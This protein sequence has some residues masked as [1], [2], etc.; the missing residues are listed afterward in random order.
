M[1][2][3]SV[4]FKFGAWAGPISEKLIQ[5]LILK[6]WGLS[7][8]AWHWP[9]SGKLIQNRADS[10]KIIF[11]E[12]RGVTKT[13][14]RKTHPNMDDISRTRSKLDR[15]AHVP[16]FSKAWIGT[17]KKMMDEFSKNR[18]SS[19]PGNWNFEKYWMSFPEIFLCL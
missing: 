14:F 15:L 3:Y 7:H 18:S 11:D 5:Q 4:L 9:I 12:F 10:R 8:A 6:F 1:S 16:I 2:T 13:G 19:C 17:R